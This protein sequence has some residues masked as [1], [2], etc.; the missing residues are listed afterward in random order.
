MQALEACQESKFD[1]I[2]M[3]VQM[4]EMDGLT[5]TQRIR[6]AEKHGQHV[7]IV[8][9]TAGAMA[10]DREKCL[11]AGMDDYIAKPFKAEDFFSRIDSIASRQDVQVLAAAVGDAVAPAKRSL[12]MSRP[13]V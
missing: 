13:A 1:M 5:A 9:L 12:A 2:F 4:P 10:S 6:R 11:A 7:T 3:D 8:A